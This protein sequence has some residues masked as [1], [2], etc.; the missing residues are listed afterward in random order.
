VLDL[1]TGEDLARIKLRGGDEPSDLALTPDGLVLVVNLGS[2]SLGFVDPASGILLDR[3]ATGLDPWTLRLDRDGRRAYVLH[4]RTG[5]ITV[6]DVAGR[7]VAR[8]VATDPEPLA[9]QLNR[10]G[11][12]LYVVHRGS[13]YM[14]VLSV[15]DLTVANRLFVGLGASALEVDPRTDLVYVGHADERRIQVFDPTSLAPIDR[16]ELPAPVSY[17]LLDRT[18]NALLA[19]MPSA[20]A[21]AFVDLASRRVT[22]VVDVGADAL[23]VAIPGERR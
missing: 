10:A 4:R 23:R 7:A 15:P 20:G 17:L 2:N 1:S 8:T 6:V 3:L 5:E 19:V 11:T 21:V 13:A 9:A 12:R 22:G 14:T 16:I 18:E